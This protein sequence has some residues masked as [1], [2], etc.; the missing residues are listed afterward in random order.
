MFRLNQ[1]KGAILSSYFNC[2]C[3]LIDEEEALLKLHFD[4]RD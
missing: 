1:R 4:E 2:N 3:K